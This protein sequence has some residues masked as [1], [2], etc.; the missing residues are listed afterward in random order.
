MREQPNKVTANDDKVGGFRRNPQRRGLRAT[1]LDERGSR[2][3][4]R[5]RASEE[6][7]GFPAQSSASGA[8]NQAR[9]EQSSTER[10]IETLHQ[11]FTAP[12]VK[13][14]MNRS[15]NRL[16]TNAIGNATRTVAA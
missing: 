6:G 9:S 4:L 3:V 11:P 8:S 16:N 14:A 10:A 1:G 15:K 2:R 5:L 13:P 12:I 7:S